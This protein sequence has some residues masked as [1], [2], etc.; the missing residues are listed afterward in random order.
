MNNPLMLNQELAKF[1][2]A[3][4]FANFRTV[5]ALIDRQDIKPQTDINVWV[6]MQASLVSSVTKI[7]PEGQSYY[8]YNLKIKRTSTPQKEWD[9]TIVVAELV[10]FLQWFVEAYS[11]TYDKVP[12][13]LIQ[14]I[15]GTSKSKNGP[16][17][18]NFLNQTV[19]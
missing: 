10:S 11:E 3:E 14:E 18:I 1:I 8:Q 4:R 19:F 5:R 16:L 9:C 2:D 13:E 7:N 17:L 15:E 6:K 12:N